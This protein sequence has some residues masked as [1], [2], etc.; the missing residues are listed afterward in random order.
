MV[1]KKMTPKLG[2]VID[3]YSIVEI[4]LLA[5]KNELA[6]EV[7]NII[8]K[9]LDYITVFGFSSSD[10]KSV[11]K[12]CFPREVDDII[13]YVHSLILRRQKIDRYFGINR[14]VDMVIA[15]QVRIIHGSVSDNRKRTV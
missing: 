10:F 2:A 8:T 5:A 1:H 15:V 12:V 7:L 14:I 13:K 4:E 6:C 11:T 9:A 3:C